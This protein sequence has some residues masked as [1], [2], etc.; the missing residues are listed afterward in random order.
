VTLTEPSDQVAEFGFAESTIML[1]E[2]AALV[3]LDRIGRS[4]TRTLPRADRNR[5]CTIR[6]SNV[7]DRHVHFDVPADQADRLLHFA[8]RQV[9]RVVPPE[10]CLRGTLESY[11][12]DLLIHRTSYDRD[13]LVAVLQRAGCV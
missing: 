2:L 8:F 3:A 9:D 4:L 7:W 10:H 11:I 1:S 6:K 13:D 12:R 5:D